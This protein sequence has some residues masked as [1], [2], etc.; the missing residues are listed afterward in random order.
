ML[1]SKKQVPNWDEYFMNIA[2]VVRSRGNCL[3]AQVGAVIVMGKRIISTGYN[4]TPIGVKNCL[5]GGCQRCLDK[6][7]GKIKSG[8]RKG[9]CLCVHAEVN[10]IVQSAYHGIP[11]RGTMLY[12]THSPCLLCAKQ[13]INAGIIGV[14]Y[15]QEDSDEAESINLLKK[16]LGR[17]MIKQV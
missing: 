5:D 15:C 13:I 11:T 12:S 2:L 17:K 8:E 9:D 4:G 10:A 14:S 6:S 1:P 7:T 16:S 3:L